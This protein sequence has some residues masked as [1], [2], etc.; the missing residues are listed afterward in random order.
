MVIHTKISKQDILTNPK[1]S[2]SIVKDAL[3]SF[4]FFLF[5][6]PKIAMELVYKAAT[7]R[8]LR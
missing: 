2:E 3:I 8:N 6:R 1:D 4:L 5:Q 7:F